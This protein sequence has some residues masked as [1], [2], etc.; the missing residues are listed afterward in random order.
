MSPPDLSARITGTSK[1]PQAERADRRT[2][3]RAWG[4]SRSGDRGKT[5]TTRGSSDGRASWGSFDDQGRG[6]AL[7]VFPALARTI[8]RPPPG[9]N[10]TGTATWRRG[11]GG[12]TIYLSHTPPPP[13]RLTAPMTLEMNHT[14][15]HRP[16]GVPHSRAA[17]HNHTFTPIE[18]TWPLV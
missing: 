7:V 18:G 15:T 10:Q 5:R 4:V 8:V 3:P 2:A 6:G 16:K 12:A 17:L 14:I 11:V 1:N 9:W 13:P